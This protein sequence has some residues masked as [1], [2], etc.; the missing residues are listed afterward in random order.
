M[1]GFN[2]AIPFKHLIGLTMTQ[3]C[4]G[5]NEIILRFEDNS[6]ILVQSLNQFLSDNRLEV[7]EGRILLPLGLGEVVE[8]CFIV[9]NRCVKITFGRNS[10]LLSDDSD[11]FESIVFELAGSRYV[12]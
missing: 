9:S 6:A 4:V 11:Q 3:I 5:A 12:I 1:Y 8:E 2:E 10:L 7:A